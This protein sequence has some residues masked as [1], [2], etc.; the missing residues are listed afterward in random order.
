LSDEEFVHAL[1]EL[2]GTPREVLEDRA[3]LDFFLPR[4]RADFA[5]CD[6]YHYAPQPPLAVPIVALGGADDTEEPLAGVIHWEHH[7]TAGCTFR[8][9]PGGHFFIHPQRKRV[10]AA[11]REAIES[12]Q[13]LATGE[14]EQHHG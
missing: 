14:K 9:L 1:T 5:A 7:T 3:L 10:I 2:E 8:V 13:A 6:R 12:A 11:V 4:L